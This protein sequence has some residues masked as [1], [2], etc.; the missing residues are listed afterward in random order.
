[1]A[2]N[3]RGAAGRDKRDFYGYKPVHFYELRPEMFR[4]RG[5]SMDWCIRRVVAIRA[6]L[7]KQGIMPQNITNNGIDNPLLSDSA[8]AYLVGQIKGRGK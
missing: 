1:M 7:V 5:Y 8:R 2:I 4:S 6:K 3:P